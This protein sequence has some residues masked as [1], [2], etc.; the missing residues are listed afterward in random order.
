MKLFAT[1]VFTPN[2][3]P[4][5]TYVRRAGED[6][7]QRLQMALS[8]PKVVVSISGPSKS[9]KTVLVEKVVGKDN[10]I[11]VSGAEVH[12]GAELWSRV[13]SWMERPA[14]VTE[15]TS[16]SVGHRVGGEA[17]GKGSIPFVAE[18]G[19]KATYDQTRTTSATV[20]ETRSDDGLARTVHEI[21][22]SDFVL[23]LDDFHY[24]PNNAQTEVAKHIKA[25]AERGIRIC[26]ATVPHR[27]DDVVRSNH[28]LRGRLAQLDTSF[29]SVE[30]LAQ[31][32]VTG[33]AKLLVDI[34]PQQAAHLAEEACGSP[35]LMQRICL[36]VCFNLNMRH[37][38]KDRTSISLERTRLQFILEQSSTHADFGTMVAN[39][40]Q[41]PKTRGTERRVHKLI[42]GSEGDVYRVLLLALA[43]GNPAL[44]VPYN[45]L[46]E[47]IGAVCTGDLPAASSIVQAC[48]QL[49]AIAKRIAPN[50][51]VLEWD[52]QDLTG[53]ISIV[54]PY[55]LFYLRC[56]RK[57][58][59]LA[60]AMPPHSG[61]QQRLLIM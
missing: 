11:P 29:W 3:F 49:D 44:V 22:N 51:R 38:Q 20:I 41:G 27:A 58:Q 54:D 55:F 32:A 52:D 57:L 43:H 45:V 31:I 34:T 25:A 56:S 1:D 16:T 19:G 6:L 39:M 5:Y 26:I 17:S 8:T 2:D 23:F 60:S 37:E 61:T 48:R 33:F 12:S 4:E 40:H 13:L 24:I 18:A 7:E 50:D 46:M 35:Q 59:K 36:D 21:A 14:S 28:E 30:E 47:R 42:D 10:L 53:T 9:G 15:Q